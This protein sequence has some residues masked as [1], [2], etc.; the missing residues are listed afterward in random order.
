M[1]VEHKLSSNQQVYSKFNESEQALRAKI[2]DLMQKNHAKDVELR[3]KEEDIF[4]L[5]REVQSMKS[6]C[7]NMQ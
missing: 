6:D 5:S 4:N 7:K 2:D 3:K 1:E